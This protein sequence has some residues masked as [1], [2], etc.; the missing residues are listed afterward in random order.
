MDHVSSY[1]IG[2]GVKECE[3]MGDRTKIVS[4]NLMGIKNGDYISFE[5]LGNSTD[6]YMGGK[7]FV[8]EGINHKEGDI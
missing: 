5:I 4:K 1:F 7:K 2:D 6:M 3:N 8:V